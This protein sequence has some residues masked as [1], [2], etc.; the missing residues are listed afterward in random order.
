MK[1]MRNTKNDANDHVWVFYFLFFHLLMKY[2][3]SLSV[4]SNYYKANVHYLILIGLIVKD[5]YRGHH[6]AN[7]SQKTH[8][9]GTAVL[10]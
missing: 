6:M 9:I 1:L 10:K 8:K 5:I 7:G 4:A 2:T 3:L